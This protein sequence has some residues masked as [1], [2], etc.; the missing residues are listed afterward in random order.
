MFL[1]INQQ[2]WQKSKGNLKFQELKEEER[3]LNWASES[4]FKVS[5]MLKRVLNLNSECYL[6]ITHSVCILYPGRGSWLGTPS[7]LRLS[8]LHFLWI[9]HKCRLAVSSLGRSQAINSLII[10][11]WSPGKVIVSFRRCYKKGTHTTTEAPFW[12]TVLKKTHFIHQAMT[13]CRFLSLP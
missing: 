1:H 12:R 8:C 11:A 3:Q 7:P 9:W 13:L 5:P 4:E 10:R 2:R 6:T